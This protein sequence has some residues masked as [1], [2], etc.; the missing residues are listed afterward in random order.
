LEDLALHVLDVVENSIAAS[1]G[2]IAILI[3]EDIGSDLLSIEITDDGRGMDEQTRAQALDPFFTTK[4]T[5]R[6]G[7]GLPLLAQAARDSDGSFELHSEPGKGTAIKA[8]FRWSH[9]DR[10]P[11]GDMLETLRTI[12]AGRPFLELEFEHRRDDSVYR[13]D[14]R[15]VK[16]EHA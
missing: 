5:K 9:P 12:M 4:G 3:D 2:R 15:E 11:L 10:K 1:A 16:P 14:T 8:V 7:L 13:F 6:V